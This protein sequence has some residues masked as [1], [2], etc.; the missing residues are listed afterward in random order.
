MNLWESSHALLIAFD[1]GGVWELV[2]HIWMQKEH[3]LHSKL[4]FSPLLLL[5][6]FPLLSSSFSYTALKNHIENVHLMSILNWRTFI[7]VSSKIFVEA[8]GESFLRASWVLWGQR[9]L[10]SSLVAQSLFH[11][12]GYFF[13][14]LF[15]LFVMKN[16]QL[17]NHEI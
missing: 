17:Y 5:G 12:S 7:S 2:S 14:H 6:G 15:S 4:F 11:S 3:I 16:C 13:V 8:S 10:H 1:T 9:M